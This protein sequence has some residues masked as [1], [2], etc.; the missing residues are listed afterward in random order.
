MKAA[1]ELFEG[2]G[3]EHASTRDVAA[4][5]GVTQAAVFRHFGTKAD[6]FVEA[7][8]QP[9]S[10]FV[11]EYLGRPE[12]SRVDDAQRSLR[13]TE[14]FVD[15]LFRL[16][17]D[18][19]RLLATMSS[20]AGAGDSDLSHRA[21]PLLADPLHRVEIEV[22]RTVAARGVP[23]MDPGVF[24]ALHLRPRVR[25]GDVERRPVPGRSRRGGSDG[26]HRDD[27]PVRAARRHSRCGTNP[28]NWIAPIS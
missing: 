22:V 19:R 20:I 24:G 1:R 15:G 14:E 10:D 7:V 11:T 18:N 21:A 8:Y 13:D 26:D 23:T 9:F 5:A 6:L 16:L 28:R 3:Y 17:V 27:V 12:E 2:R 4:R 25:S